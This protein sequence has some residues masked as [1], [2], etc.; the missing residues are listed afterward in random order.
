VAR[1]IGSGAVWEGGLLY[2]VESCI[3]G[4][5]EGMGARKGMLDALERNEGAFEGCGSARKEEN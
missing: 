5:Q 2:T 1:E 3:Y 4:P